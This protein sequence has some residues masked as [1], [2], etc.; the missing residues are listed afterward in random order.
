MSY[1][2][3]KGKKRS[4][5]PKVVTVDFTLKKFYVFPQNSRKGYAEIGFSFG[6][7]EPKLLHHESKKV[8]FDLERIVDVECFSTEENNEKYFLFVEGCPIERN[9]TDQ[10][11]CH[12]GVHKFAI[13]KKYPESSSIVNGLAENTSLWSV[14]AQ[15][16]D[17]KPLRQ[18]FLLLLF[19]NGR[20]ELKVTNIH[21]DSPC[22][23]VKK[24]FLRMEKLCVLHVD[25]LQQR[26][27]VLNIEADCI[28]PNYYRCT[29]LIGP[30][31]YEQL[32]DCPVAQL[33]KR[34]RKEIENIWAS[35]E[36]AVAIA[37]KGRVG[38]ALLHHPLVPGKVVKRIGT[39]YG[40]Q[41]NPYL[42]SF[43]HDSDYETKEA[44]I[45]A[46]AN[47]F[48]LLYYGETQVLFVPLSPKLKLKAV[49]DDVRRVHIGRKII[50]PTV[51]L[52]TDD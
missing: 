23:S 17:V 19:C 15:I 47:G 5:Y 37:Y 35:N 44:K 48:V 34:C 11:S 29:F 18:G 51:T 13:G 41:R 2:I 1:T 50:Q 24:I 39:D 4:N 36:V 6:P 12:Y 40:C 28:H 38:Y 33:Y 43:F 52:F 20:E 45:T 30:G 10:G 25:P 8:S 22:E 27:T 16:L 7:R 3:N 49:R 42:P 32:Y 26:A 31:L 21:K 14:N 46:V 9:S